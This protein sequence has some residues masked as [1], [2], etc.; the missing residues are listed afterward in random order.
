MRIDSASY[1]TGQVAVPPERNETRPAIS[2]SAFMSLR[3]VAFGTAAMSS[4][5][6]LRLGAQFFALPL[7]ARLLSPHDYGVV[8]MAMPF[9]AFT[10]MFADA[11]IGMSLVRSPAADR[12]ASAEPCAKPVAKRTPCSSAT[13]SH[14]KRGAC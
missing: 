13:V 4:V 2:A 7:L 14:P 11:G 3:R 1:P 8:G 10:L 9:L 12:R 5:N 6:V